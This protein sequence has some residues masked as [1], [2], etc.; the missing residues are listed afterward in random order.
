[1]LLI[2]LLDIYS[3]IVFGAVIISWMGLSQDNPIANFLYSMTEP[4]LAPIRQILPDM[5]GIDLS[6][7]AL[8]FGI[9]I[10]RGV[11]LAALLGP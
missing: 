7:V 2:Q 10:L 1:M 6:P 11:L 8:L 5:G 4:L 3:V 9:R